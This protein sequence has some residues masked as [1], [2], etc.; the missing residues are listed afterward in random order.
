MLT[1]ALRLARIALALALGASLLGAPAAGAKVSSSASGGLLKV[2][3]GRGSDRI[4]VDCVGGAVKVNNRN[5]RTGPVACSQISEVDVVSG[6]GN[7]HLDL[8][9]VGSANGFGQRDV[10]GGFGHGTG[11]GAQLGDGN[12]TYV[13]GKSCFNLVLAGAGND[14]ASG[15]DGRDELEGGQGNDRLAGG[16]GRDV[17]VGNAGGDT[18]KGG[19]DDDVLS[20]N[21][22]DDFLIGGAGNDLLGGGSGDDHLSGGPGD[23]E[24][25]G[26]KGNDTLNGGPGDN[27][28]V[29]DSPPRRS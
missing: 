8:S 18:L 23:D 17:L 3:G 11:C 7:D 9:G 15:G 22:G 25:I 13:G 5:P 16:G 20:G 21:S 1:P 24:L 28:L 6:P 26:G 2:R 14:R 27:T 4:T 12:D 19:A 10:P 29:Q